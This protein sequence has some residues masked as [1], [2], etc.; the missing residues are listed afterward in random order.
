MKLLTFMTILPQSPQFD[1]TDK[2]PTTSEMARLLHGNV[3]DRELEA[4]ASHLEGCSGCETTLDEFSEDSDIGIQLLLSLPPTAEDELAFRELH[5][6][7]T[8]T[9]LMFC[10]DE[11]MD[12]LASGE[13]REDSLADLTLPARVGQ[14]ELLSADRHRC[15]GDRL[16]RSASRVSS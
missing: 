15:Y 5:A 16:S 7:L 9:P 11:S 10:G 8:S 12:D 14:Y 1:G 6:L 4:L 13:D 2:C 3:S